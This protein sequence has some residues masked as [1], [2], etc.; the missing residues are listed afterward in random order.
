MAHGL[1]G[2]VLEDDPK[3]E[4]QDKADGPIGEEY[5]APK[6]QRKGRKDACRGEVAQGAA[7]AAV[8]GCQNHALPE[9]PARPHAVLHFPILMARL[10]R[11]NPSDVVISPQA[12][13]TRI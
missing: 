6:D 7:A 5:S 4:R 11:S 9:W 2:E 12:K 13:G 3:G 8:A 1:D 10:H